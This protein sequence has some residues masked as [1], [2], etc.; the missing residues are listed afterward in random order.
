M[1]R[2]GEGEI[3]SDGTKAG[4]VSDGPQTEKLLC[5]PLISESE[6]KLPADTETVLVVSG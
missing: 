4:R 1:G 5:R 3:G 2:G 6:L